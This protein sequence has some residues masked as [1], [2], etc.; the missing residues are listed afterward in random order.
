MTET[1]KKSVKPAEPKCF[2]I[3]PV[4]AGGEDLEDEFKSHFP[5]IAERMFRLNTRALEP[6]GGGINTIFT[7]LTDIRATKQVLGGGRE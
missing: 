5:K 6:E 2:D 1:E 7:I 4:V 3:F